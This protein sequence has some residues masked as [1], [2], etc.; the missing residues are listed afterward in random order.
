MNAIE[1]KNLTKKYK[2]KLAVN[3]LDL[4]IKKMIADLFASI[5]SL[6]SL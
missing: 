3:N 1:T 2:D 6:N 5:I 4:E